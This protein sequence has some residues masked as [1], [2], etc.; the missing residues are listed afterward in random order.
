MRL[1]TID[2]Q[3]ANKLLRA[4]SSQQRA[5][6]LL[7]SELAIKATH[8]QDSLVLD[9]LEILRKEGRLSFEIRN[10]LNKLV[11]RFDEEYF[12]LQNKVDSDGDANADCLRVF[13][14]A[15]A[16]SALSFAGVEES[17][18]AAAES[19]YEASACFDDSNYIFDAVTNILN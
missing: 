2:A 13:S 17:Y 4:S 1:D 6:S 15:R 18:E 3:I 14:Q 8:I 11:E 9:A 5:A 7:A 19:I 10:D 12:D 16:V